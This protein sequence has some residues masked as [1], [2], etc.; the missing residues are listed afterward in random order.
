MKKT[1]NLFGFFALMAITGILVL[2]CDNDL[3]NNENGDIIPDYVIPEIWR[4]VFCFGNVGQ[5]YGN[6]VP[7]AC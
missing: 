4:G 7:R 5:G 1:I 2:S 6:I 3:I